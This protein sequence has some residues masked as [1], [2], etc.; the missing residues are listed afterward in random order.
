MLITA[1]RQPPHST[2]PDPLHS[3]VQPTVGARVRYI[4]LSLEAGGCDDQYWTSIL[5]APLLKVLSSERSER[6]GFGMS[7]SLDGLFVG[8][9][10]SGEEIF[11]SQRSRGP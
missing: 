9:G 4:T 8:D 6:G 5:R 7:A 2:D 10:R 11:A 1:T 3:M